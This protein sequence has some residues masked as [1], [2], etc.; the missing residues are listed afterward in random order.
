[1]QLVF[2]LPGG[3]LLYNTSKNADSTASLA[4]APLLLMMKCPLTTEESVFGQQCQTHM[5]ISM[6]KESTRGLVYKLIPVLARYT[7]T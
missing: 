6:Q 1:M 2:P 4:L 3:A 7:I 5:Q